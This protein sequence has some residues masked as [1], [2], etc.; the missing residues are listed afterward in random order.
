MIT[1]NDSG[2]GGVEISIEGSPAQISIELGFIVSCV[3]EQVLTLAKEEANP[4]D[5]S[6]AV[7]LL[8]KESVEFGLEYAKKEYLKTSGKTKKIKKIE[9]DTGVDAKIAAMLKQL[10]GM[11][12]EENRK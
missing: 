8:F 4:D 9:V 11:G 2:R 6:E 7:E 5:V 12:L 1:V 3:V 10:Q